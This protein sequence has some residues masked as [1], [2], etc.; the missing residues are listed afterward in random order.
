MSRLEP[1]TPPASAVAKPLPRLHVVTD[2]E[3][4]AE[5]AFDESARAL[6]RAF[7]GALALHLRG[8]ETS[9]A[10]L[11]GLA[12]PLAAAASESGSLLLVNDRL[13]VALAAGAGG[14]QLGRRSLEPRVGRLLGPGLRIGYSAH[15]VGEAHEALES[16]ADFIVLGSVYPT[17]S[18]PHSPGSG[19]RLIR[20]AGAL[21]APL[22]AIGGITPERVEDVMES[23]AYGVAVLSGVWRSG[24]PRRAVEQYLSAIRT[25]R[26]G[27]RREA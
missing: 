9:P 21:D 4:L 6:L 11:F 1:A 5:D 16:G 3:V 27:S 13:D 2:D 18:H 25:T 20:E 22:I 23:G 15:A 10:V 12:E 14:A 26:G 19:T 8:H 24:D 17:P 7:A